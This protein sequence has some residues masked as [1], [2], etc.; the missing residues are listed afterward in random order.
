MG[1]VRAWAARR[2]SAALAQVRPPQVA[3]HAVRVRRGHLWATL[4]GEGV[5]RHV[6]N[7]DLALRFGR[8]Y[9]N[10]TLDITGARA[11]GGTLCRFSTP[12]TAA[13]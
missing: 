10:L 11:A 1:G 7:V 3:L 2:I 5:P 9:N 4:T 6:Q 13:P 12:C 8:D